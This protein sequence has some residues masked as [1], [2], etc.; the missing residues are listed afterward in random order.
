MPLHREEEGRN[1]RCVDG[2]DQA[3]LRVGQRLEA[4]AEGGFAEARTIGRLDAGA[5]R[6]TVT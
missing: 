2:L 5:P 1:A 3:V 4:F 6:L